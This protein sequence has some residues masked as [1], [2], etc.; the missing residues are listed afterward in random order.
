MTE[1]Q[2]YL[3][4]CNGFPV[5]GITITRATVESVLAMARAVPGVTAVSIDGDLEAGLKIRFPA[6][7]PWE[8]EPAGTEE[9][10]FTFTPVSTG[11]P[12]PDP[13]KP[14]NT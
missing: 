6:G 9:R 5:D 3:R 2:L 13:T 11:R 14:P 12:S 4:R 1:N 7:R 8:V 10:T